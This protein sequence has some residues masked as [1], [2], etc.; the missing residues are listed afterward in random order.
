[1][2]Q[3]VDHAP[4]KPFPLSNLERLARSKQTGNAAH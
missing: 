3:S 4:D 2:D 1:V